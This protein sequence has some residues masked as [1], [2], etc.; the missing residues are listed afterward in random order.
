[1][2]HSRDQEVIKQFGKRVRSLRVSKGLSQEA[3]ANLANLEISQVNRIE[4]GKIN[5]SIS[6][7]AILANALEVD[8]YKLFIK[9][10]LNSIK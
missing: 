7:A 8:L 3:L 2:K 10:S 4:L 5:T 1:M 6:H 9:D